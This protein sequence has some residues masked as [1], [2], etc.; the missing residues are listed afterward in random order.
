MTTTTQQQQQPNIRERYMRYMGDKLIEGADYEQFIKHKIKRLGIYIEPYREKIRQYLL[1]ENSN[2]IEIKY[3]AKMKKT[4]NIYIE[5]YEKNPWLKD[6]TPSGINRQ[7]NSWLYV[8]GDYDVF[9]IFSKKTLKYFL[10]KIDDIVVDNTLIKH[11]QYR[12]K[13]FKTSKGYLLPVEDAQYLAEKI[14][15]NKYD[16]ILIENDFDFYDNY[17][18]NLNFIN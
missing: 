14:I 12:E 16:N 5:T 2:G 8:I 7:D 6:W 3:D 10:S 9:Y 4:N 17:L 1:G 18:L 13:E 15:I 11:Q